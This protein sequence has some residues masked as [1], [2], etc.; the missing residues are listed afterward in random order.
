M[1]K[2][3]AI[4]VAAGSSRRMGFDKLLAPLDGDVLLG[5][6]LRAFELCKTVG[7]IILVTRDDMFEL[8]TE[9]SITHGIS[10]LQTMIPGGAQ[11]C[12]SVWA[13]IQAARADLPYIAVHDGARPLIRPEDI[14]ACLGV[15]EEHGAA[16][17]AAPVV[18]TLKLAHAPELLLA[19]GVS[20]EN[21][22]AMQ[23]P[24]IFRRD[25]LLRAYEATM[26]AGQEVTDETSALE[27]LGIPVALYHNPRWN[28]KITYPADL[29]LAEAWVTR[30]T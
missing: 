2:I 10:K 27:A 24:Q 7:E 9:F 28:P 16:S 1:P 5:H 20:R 14:T 23:T 26:A 22:W 3:S 25:L 17:C 19:G 12:H 30:K 4:I 21:L 13:G 8:M 15:A 6:S 18:D 29:E 11:R